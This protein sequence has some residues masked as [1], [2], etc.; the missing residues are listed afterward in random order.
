M[1]NAKLA[2][3][4]LAFF[5]TTGTVLAVAELKFEV[6]LKRADDKPKST[7]ISWIDFYR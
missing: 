1:T 3:T 4:M 5:C 2:V 6:I 7:S